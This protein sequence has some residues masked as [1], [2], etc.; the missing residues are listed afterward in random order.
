MLRMGLK[1]RGQDLRQ[2]FTYKNVDI[3]QL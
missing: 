3:L 1:V 2:N